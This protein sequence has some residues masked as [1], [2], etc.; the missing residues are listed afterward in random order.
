M[1]L[2]PLGRVHIF[3]GGWIVFTGYLTQIASGGANGWVFGVL[4]L[5]MQHDLGWSRSTIVGWFGSL[6]R[7]SS[8]SGLC[9]IGQRGYCCG[10]GQGVCATRHAV[11]IWCQGHALIQ[12]LS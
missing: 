7:G 12:A 10:L 1:S 8:C 2:G 11:A 4:I 3:R 5:P 6:G 9:G